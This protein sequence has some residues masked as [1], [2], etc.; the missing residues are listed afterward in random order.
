M[1]K[2]PKSTS[3]QLDSAV[4]APPP[5]TVTTGSSGDNQNP[6]MKSWHAKAANAASDQRRYAALAV[7]LIFFIVLLVGMAS[8]PSAAASLA[9]SRPAP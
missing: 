3:A 9:V 6:T 4:Q 8:S 7:G 2:R 1:L 5:I